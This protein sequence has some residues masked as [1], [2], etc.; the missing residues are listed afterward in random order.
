MRRTTLG[1]L[2]AVA[3]HVAHPAVAASLIVNG[4]FESASV[5]PGPLDGC[6]QLG[7]G[8]TSI[9]GW[10]V[11]GVN[12]EY[13]GQLFWLAAD[14]T[15]SVDLEGNQIGGIRQTFAT[16]A[17]Q[18][19][20]VTFAMGGNASGLPVVKSMQASADGQSQIFQ[21][22]TTGSVQGWTQ[23]T[24]TFTADDGSATLEFASVGTP[25]NGYGPLLD[26]VV[27]TPEPAALM[28]LAVAGVVIAS[29]QRRG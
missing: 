12:I 16:V 15:R 25:N 9:A 14:G 18:L 28:L 11:T 4:S 6:V 8:D 7:A 2:V 23:M 10:E 5:S 13:C 3:T 24:F 29:R 21:F 1:L 20:T 22:D 26:S 19:Y 17:G 27:V